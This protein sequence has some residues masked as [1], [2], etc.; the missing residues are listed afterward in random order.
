MQINI[1]E[2]RRCNMGSQEEKEIRD[3]IQYLENKDGLSAKEYER[4][5]ILKKKL[6][7]D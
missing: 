7:E 4:L 1:A 6:N 5:R 2:E 3:E